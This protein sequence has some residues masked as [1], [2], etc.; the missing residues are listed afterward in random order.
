MQCQA[1]LAEPSKLELE[2]KLEAFTPQSLKNQASKK[3][4]FLTT[5]IAASQEEA[6]RLEKRSKP[7][8]Q[9]VCKSYRSLSFKMRLL[10]LVPIL[11]AFHLTWSLESFDISCPSNWEIIDITVTKQNTD[12]LEFSVNCFPCHNVAWSNKKFS[13]VMETSGE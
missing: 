3:S 6:F 5:L 1:F 12:R 2:L 4:S 10:L 7:Q 9:C 11:T 8:L 13:V